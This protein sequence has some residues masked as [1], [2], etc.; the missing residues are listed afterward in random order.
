MSFCFFS[1]THEHLSH[2]SYHLGHFSYHLGGLCVDP[3][4][5]PCVR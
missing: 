2:F 5:I 3:T 1:F 4:T